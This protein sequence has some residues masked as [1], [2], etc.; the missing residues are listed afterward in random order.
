MITLFKTVHEWRAQRAGMESN[1]GGT[2]SEPQALGFVPTMGALHEGHLSLVRRSKAENDRTLVSLFV[3]ATQFNDRADYTAYPRTMEADL[4]MLETAGV[5]YVFAPEHE[6]L[7]PDGYRYRINETEFSPTLCGAHRPGHFE[8]MLTVVMKLLQI[9]QAHRAYFGEKDYQQVQLVRGMSEAF[10]LQTEI[11]PCPIIRE[12]DGLAMSSRNQRLSHE[13]RK[14]AA[15]LPRILRTAQSPAMA[16]AA[17]EA[18]GFRVD[19]VEDHFG[20]RLGAAHLGSVRLIDN[21]ER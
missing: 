21:V 14:L 7:Y 19:Y 9:A 1:R 16:T 6:E 17:L 2:K 10:F 20:R 8:G 11:V 4:S 15:E 18:L 3:N 13:E 5:D 12:A